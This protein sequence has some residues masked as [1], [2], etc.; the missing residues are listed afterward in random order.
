MGVL[1][2]WQ[3]ELAHR[4]HSCAGNRFLLEIF[5]PSLS[6][7]SEDSN[8]FP[9]RYKSKV[10]KTDVWAYLNAHDE[11]RICFAVARG[12]YLFANATRA[13]KLLSDAHRIAVK[14]IHTDRMSQYMQMRNRQKG[15]LTNKVFQTEN[16]AMLS[17]SAN[18]K[19]PH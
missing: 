7:Q 4:A 1:A 16:S 10:S 2:S 19:T 9:F 11:F 6:V 13:R 12:I 17:H 8:G 14:G 5:L 15:E 18:S 3:A